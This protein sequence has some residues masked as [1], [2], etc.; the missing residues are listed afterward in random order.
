M[1]WFDL[2]TIFFAQF[3][4]FLFGLLSSEV[5][6]WRWPRFAMGGSSASGRFTAV[7]QMEGTQ[8]DTSRRTCDTKL[9]VIWA[10]PP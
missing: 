7:G 6:M 1:R 9:A 4:D 5:G 10:R 3:L 8:A 2:F